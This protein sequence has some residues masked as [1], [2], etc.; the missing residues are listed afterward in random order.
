[1]MILSANAEVVMARAKIATIF[2]IWIFPKKFILK[3]KK[4]SCGSGPRYGWRSMSIT[5]VKGFDYPRRQFCP[6][7]APAGVAEFIYNSSS[8]RWKFC[9]AQLLFKRTRA[10]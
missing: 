5:M 2:F 6:T 9:G 8:S 4:F 7:S 1:M 3:Y 10:C